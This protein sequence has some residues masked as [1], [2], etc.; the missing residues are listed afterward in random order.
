M[1]PKNSLVEKYTFAKGQFV[2]GG[3]ASLKEE[4]WEKWLS[5]AKAKPLLEGT[6]DEPSKDASAKEGKQ[7]QASA[8]GIRAS[9]NASAI[10]PSHSILPIAV[11][12]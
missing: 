5:K 2:G 12:V 10:E 8:S 11:E 1:P 3:S 7:R 9:A 4:R 6:E